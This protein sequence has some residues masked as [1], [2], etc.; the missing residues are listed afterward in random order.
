MVAGGGT[1]RG[2][3]KKAV[4]ALAAVMG[5]E[6][7]KKRKSRGATVRAKKYGYK[8]N[9]HAVDCVKAMSLLVRGNPTYTLRR[10]MVQGLVQLPLVRKA[11]GEWTPQKL[12]P[13]KRGRYVSRVRRDRT[14]S[15]NAVV[16]KNGQEIG[17]FT[18]PHGLFVSKSASASRNMVAKQFKAKPKPAAA[19]AEAVVAADEAAAAH[20]A[21]AKSADRL[22]AVS[23]PGSDAKKAAK[24]TAAKATKKKTAT[25]RLLEENIKRAEEEAAIRARRGKK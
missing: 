25:E 12:T 5:S 13:T 4:A 19:I 20:A 6:A 2:K 22:A 17:K 23:T 7:P 1:L 15:R 21:V 14:R 11:K 3:S 18:A 24:K 16:M 10:A 8:R 9:K